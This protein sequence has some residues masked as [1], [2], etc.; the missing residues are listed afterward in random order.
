MMNNA[1]LT[2]EAIYRS[3]YLLAQQTANKAVAGTLIID[4]PYYPLTSFLWISD[5]W[6]SLPTGV[7]KST[8]LQIVKP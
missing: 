6:N 3:M 8:L 5:C 2:R 1:A 7:K 4:K